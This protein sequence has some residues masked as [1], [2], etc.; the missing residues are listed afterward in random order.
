MS[1]SHLEEASRAASRSARAGGG[2]ATR[3]EVGGGR[4]EGEAEG[5]RRRGGEEGKKRGVHLGWFTY[6]VLPTKSG[7]A[8]EGA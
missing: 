5:E 8:T 2:S 4:G 6:V 1:L 7:G 3:G